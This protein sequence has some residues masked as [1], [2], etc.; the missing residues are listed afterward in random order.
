M[1]PSEAATAVQ[2]HG[3]VRA[4]S[5]A[6]GVP[7]T[8]LRDKA[9][10]ARQ[11]G[12]R[13]AAAPRGPGPKSITARVPTRAQESVESL[14][15]SRVADARR[16]SDY[17]TAMEWVPIRINE[18][19]PFGILIFGD[20][21]L[22]DDGCDWPRL[23]SDIAIARDTPGVYAI[24]AGDAHNNWIGRLERLYASQNTS[25][26][27]AWRLV[28]WYLNGAGVPWL[29]RLLG[30]HDKW[31]NGAELM[32]LHN[33]LGVPLF[34]WRAAI[35]LECGN[36]RTINIRAAHDFPGMSQWNKTHA[37]VKAALM[38]YGDADV[39]LCGHR[40]T[41]GVQKF[42]H[43]DRCPLAVRVGSYKR[44]DDYALTKGFTQDRHG[45]SMML[46]IDP[47]AKTADGLVECFYDPMQGARFLTAL[48]ATSPVTAKRR[49]AT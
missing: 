32:H 1:T 44:D 26:E 24:G 3:G 30:N 9:A 40:H 46:I 43:R 31:G 35:A 36:G 42:E 2:E 5:R 48:R 20:E 33:S 29:F 14:I 22:D 18:V 38:T 15:N 21:H 12:A 11:A 34:D 13:A 27:T 16:R 39:Y 10:K 47:A 17:R 25:A 37:L 41:G 23:L 49:R 28:Q 4:A 45:A 6:L 19:R 7:Y 8:T